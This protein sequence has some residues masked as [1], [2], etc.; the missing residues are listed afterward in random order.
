MNAC[1]L[2]A[3]YNLIRLFLFQLD[4]ETSHNLIV[5]LLKKY[6]SFLSEY[7]PQEALKQTIFSK[8][9]KT[10]IGLA[11]G[12]D[13]YGE[14]FP[15]L[16]AFGFGYYEL[17][18]FT[19]RSQAGGPKPRMKR[20]ISQKALINKMGFNNPGLER[21][22][23]NIRRSLSKDQE[24]LSL[25]GIS[26]GRSKNTRNQD[27]LE[28]YQKMLAYIDLKENKDIHE[29]I[30]YIA[31][32]ISSPNT[33]GLR[34]LQNKK[35]LSRIVRSLKKTS[36]LPL[37][38]KFAPDFEELTQFRGLLEATALAG[39]DGFILVNTSTN[40]RLLKGR[41]GLKNLGGGISGEPLRK[42][43]ETYLKETYDIIGESK[44]IISSGGIMSPE[45][46]WRRLI[47]GASLVQ[48]YTGLIYYGPAFLLR[49]FE[50][51]LRQLKKYKL[52]SLPTLLKN[53]KYIQ[54]EILTSHKL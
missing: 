52:D 54:T 30:F 39:A 20:V 25:I 37:V 15:F 11:A 28:E 48:V 35:D 7:H 5:S 13:K 24:L 53:R 40:Y 4:A 27:A 38:I 51:I 1:V 50:Y 43:A 22:I 49:S 2:N 44:K 3:F 10:P 32:N 17:G 8:E 45:D 29:K 18:S 21:G 26:L 16:D 46:V 23:Q 47:L 36:R 42:I 19:L 41:L 31:V 6:S 9:V 33:P 14:L 34:E 12:F